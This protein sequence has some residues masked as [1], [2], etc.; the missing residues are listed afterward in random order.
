MQHSKKFA[1]FV[2]SNA[3]GTDVWLSDFC[4]VTGNAGL[5]VG[6]A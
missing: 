5:T 4:K 3:L 6:E 2:L 1:N